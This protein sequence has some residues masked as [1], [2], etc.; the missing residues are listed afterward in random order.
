LAAWRA[1]TYDIASRV[2]AA[3]CKGGAMVT[4]GRAGPLTDRP[5]PLQCLNREPGFPLHRSLRVAAP[6]ARAG[7]TAG[8]CAGDAV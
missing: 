8:S 5:G 2:I 1:A 6:P 7:T 3:V 4:G